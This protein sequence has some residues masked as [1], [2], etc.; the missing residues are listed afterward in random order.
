MESESE[1]EYDSSDNEKDDE[2]SQV[3]YDRLYEE[4]CKLIEALNKQ[5]SKNEILKDKIETLTNERNIL[6]IEL[7]KINSKFQIANEKFNKIKSYEKEAE[8]LNKINSHLRDEVTQ[9]KW[10]KEKYAYSF[11]HGQENFERLFKMR[12]FHRDKTRLGHNKIYRHNPNGSTV[13]V[14]GETSSNSQNIS[15]I[16]CHSCG[17]KGHVKYECKMKKN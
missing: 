9:L 3:T 8:T 15:E 13:F 1:S 12:K 14:K 2:D 6:A 11:T 5:K 10:F 16:T 4:S 17:S 7:N